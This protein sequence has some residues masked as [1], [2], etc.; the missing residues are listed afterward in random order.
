MKNKIGVIGAGVVGNAIAFGF[1]KAGHTVKIHDI[2]LNTSI[3]DV[4]DTEI[5]Y[6]CVPT[7]SLENSRCDV[8][9]VESVVDELV[10]LEYEG[11]IAI[12]ST[13]E[14]GTT[15]MLISKYSDRQVVRT[16]DARATSRYRIC[17]VPEFLRERC[18]IADFTENHDACIIGSLD[19]SGYEDSPFEVVKRSHKP[20]PKKFIRC[21]PTEA[22]LCKYFN[23][24]YNA[25][26]ITFA[27]SFYELC[28]KKNVD[29]SKVKNI[30]VHRTNINNAYLDATETFRGFGGQCL[31]K[32]TQAIA[33][34]LH[35]L[36]VDVDFFDCI[37]HENA[38]YKTTVFDGMRK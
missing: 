36:G 2:K 12:K 18:A 5:V 35:D 24:L 23:N 10:K 9:I 28:K 1:S 33:S 38:K 20:Y 32:D 19:D 37:L 29:Y 17:F 7:P 11:V 16:Q 30:C 34:L 31:T 4:L 21:T 8:S 13:V 3:S 14:P 6:I 27:N 15:D 26:L 22:E 25:T